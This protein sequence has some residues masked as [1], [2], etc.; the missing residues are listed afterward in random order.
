LFQHE[1]R[2]LSLS[3]SRKAAGPKPS[4]KPALEALEERVV[5]SG[6]IDITPSVQAS[7]LLAQAQGI[8][9]HQEGL[10]RELQSYWHVGVPVPPP[11]G[12][13]PLYVMLPTPE[14]VEA[15]RTIL[16]RED[17]LGR[18][19]DGLVKAHPHN[20]ALR[21]LDHQFHTRDHDFD[22]ARG[23]VASHLG[24]QRCASSVDSLPLS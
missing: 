13:L 14:D 22:G 4:Y 1:R 9:K 24:L 20:A 23:W 10:Y 5:L 3:A 19:L 12:I 16:A 18:Q 11:P 21:A 2:E 17:A 15:V 8:L 6:M 7:C